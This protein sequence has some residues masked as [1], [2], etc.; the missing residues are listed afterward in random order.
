MISIVWASL[1][2]YLI[3]RKPGL[4]WIAGG[5]VFGFVVFFAMQ[6]VTVLAHV[7]AGG[8]PSARDFAFFVVAHCLF[9]GLPVSWYVSRTTAQTA[10]RSS[11]AM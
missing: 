2:A 7:S 4:N 6:A 9:F 10:A 5:I 1:Y 8:A 11:Q 3:V